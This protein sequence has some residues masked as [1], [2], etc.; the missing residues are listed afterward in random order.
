MTPPTATTASQSKAFIWMDR[1]ACVIAL[2]TI[3]D[4]LLAIPN[5]VGARVRNALSQTLFAIAASLEHIPLLS[6]GSDLSVVLSSLILCVLLFGPGLF[7]RSGRHSRLGQLL[8]H[9]AA[10]PAT[11]GL[12]A[13]LGW[14]AG[15]A[16]TGASLLILMVALGAPAV[17]ERPSLARVG[18][19]GLIGLS[20]VTFAHAVYVSGP[21]IQPTLLGDAGPVAALG[22]L[23]AGLPHEPAFRSVCQVAVGLLVL[24]GVARLHLVHRSAF[25][26]FSAGPAE[27]L[28]PLCRLFGLTLL[29]S[30]PAQALDILRCPPLPAPMTLVDARPGTFQMAFTPERLWAVDR[31]G[32]RVRGFALPDG[33][34]LPDNQLRGGWPEEIASTP[35]G[36]WLAQVPVGGDGS[37]L[38]QLDPRTGAA[39]SRNPI[40]ECFVA[41]TL[42]LPGQETLL[43]GCEYQGRVVRFLPATGQYSTSQ[44]VPGLGSVESLVQTR[45]G[46]LAAPLWDGDKLVRLDSETLLPLDSRFVGDFGW[47]LASSGELVALGRFQEG[48]VDLFDS[49]LTRLGSIKVGFG[50][51]DVVLWTSDDGSS[52]VIALASGSGQVTA[53][54]ATG[55]PTRRVRIGGGARDLALRG[56]ALYLGGRCGIA[57]L[58][59]ERWLGRS[60][61]TD[62]SPVP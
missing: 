53:A 36:L 23:L 48:R 12:L 18:L 3:F 1:G 29:L 39:K 51:R 49:S 40:P 5:T 7:L 19:A 16:P 13:G 38:S 32:T 57:S 37:V 31:Q 46:I 24:G 42:W 21:G 8:L 4:V 61:T 58:D 59:L 27:W 50:V 30:L 35:R 60:P 33:R 28:V 62:L 41:S 56:D 6:D 9:A 2:L 55:G 26:R 34:A 43:L 44:Q 54:R 25:P 17:P 10:M 45:R 22:S 14:A 11:L 47:G 20:G 15:L 52:W